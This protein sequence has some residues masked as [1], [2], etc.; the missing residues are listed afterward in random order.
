MRDG[1]ENEIAA[2]VELVEQNEQ[3]D[4]I[5]AARDRGDNASIRTPQL[6]SSREA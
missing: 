6:M 1:I 4:R 2:K 3:R 5:S